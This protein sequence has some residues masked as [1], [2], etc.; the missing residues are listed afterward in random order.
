M[1]V[2]T[3]LTRL[4]PPF[5]N[6]VF[7]TCEISFVDG[8]QYSSKNR[9]AQFDIREALTICGNYAWQQK[10]GRIVFW[11]DDKSIPL[12]PGTT[13]LFPSGTKRFS[14]IGVEPGESICIF[15]QYCHA[16][17]LRFFARGCQSDAQFEAA[18]SEEDL[19]AYKITREDRPLASMKLYSKMDDIF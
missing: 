15:R 1:N 6:S 8:P 11:D 3:D 14:F 9:E 12:R 2:I 18:M 16:G 5:K 10:H 13:V 19:A 4:C 7:T 17:V